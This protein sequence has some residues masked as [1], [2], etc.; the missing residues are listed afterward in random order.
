MVKLTNLHLR[1]S[2]LHKAANIKPLIFSS[3]LQ[4]IVVVACVVLC[5]SLYF[6]FYF[7]CVFLLF[8]LKNLE[9]NMLHIESSL[10]Q[11]QQNGQ[12]RRKPSE[13]T[14]MPFC[15]HLLYRWD[16][17]SYWA[18]RLNCIFPMNN[19][20]KIW[21]NKYTIETNIIKMSD[22]FTKLCQPKWLTNTMNLP[23]SNS[24]KIWI[25]EYTT[26][27]NIIQMSNREN[28]TDFVSFNIYIIKRHI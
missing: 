20:K 12:T 21:I 24:K 3:Q 4:Y 27:T 25:N 7:F 13:H 2:R 18:R 10:L 1:V 16:N 22:R 15:G 9:E 23:M 5:D 6:L 26:E 11:C 19:P 14:I 28:G 17:G 8:S